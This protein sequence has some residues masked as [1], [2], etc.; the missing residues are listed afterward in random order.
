MKLVENSG[1]SALA[2]ITTA[3]LAHESLAPAPVTGCRGIDL[4]ELLTTPLGSSPT[5]DHALQAIPR[6]FDPKYS[7]QSSLKG[8]RRYNPACEY[9]IAQCAC[10][11]VCYFRNYWQMSLLVQ[12]NTYFARHRLFWVPDL[13]LQSKSYNS[14]CLKIELKFCLS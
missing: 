2:W 4:G 5:V 6:Y 10:Y 13:T 1:K 14:I 9:G 8:H 7:C 12:V 11:S 3:Y